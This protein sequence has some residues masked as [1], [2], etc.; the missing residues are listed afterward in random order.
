M[1]D[2]LLNRV[3][4]EGERAE[5]LPKLTPRCPYC[6]E[7]P[8]KFVTAYVEAGELATM[9]VYCAVQKC[10]KIFTIQVLGPTGRAMT[11]RQT[12]IVPPNGRLI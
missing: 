4:Q 3:P 6:G 1:I 12:L 10:R 9:V 11:E 2:E 7:D 8:A 5:K